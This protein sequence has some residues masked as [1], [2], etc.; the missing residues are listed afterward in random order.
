MF[1]LQNDSE[2]ELSCDEIK[3]MEKIAYR[4]EKG[5]NVLVTW[6]NINGVIFERSFSYIDTHFAKEDFEKLKTLALSFEKELKMLNEEC[7]A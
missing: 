2:T 6:F 5:R 4:P 3:R 1:I 7:N